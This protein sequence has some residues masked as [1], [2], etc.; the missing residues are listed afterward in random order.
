LNHK[1]WYIN[2][3]LRANV[4]TR[5]IIKSKV[6]PKKTRQIKTKLRKNLKTSDFTA[7]L[8]PLYRCLIKTFSGT[9]ATTF[10]VG[11]FSY[12]ETNRNC[13]S[14]F[15]TR[16]PKWEKN[17]HVKSRF[18]CILESF[19]STSITTGLWKRSY[20]DFYIKFFE[21]KVL[22]DQNALKI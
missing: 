2:L 1:N 10:C 13:N 4:P 14:N 19:D 16:S 11:V 7:L 3:S 22:E 8:T 15:T 20:I 9:N 5:N 12:F 6:F 17:T 21:K 18:I